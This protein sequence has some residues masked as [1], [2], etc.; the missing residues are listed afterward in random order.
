MMTHRRR[1]WSISNNGEMTVST[2]FD[3]YRLSKWSW[4]HENSADKWKCHHELDVRSRKFVVD[5]D[6]NH[7]MTRA[8][9]RLSA[10]I[11]FQTPRYI[12]SWL[13]NLNA[14]IDYQHDVDSW[15]N[16][17]RTNFQWGRYAF[18]HEHDLD[19]QPYTA[20][21]TTV[22][23]TTPF[24]GLEQLGIGFNNRRTLNGWRANNELLMGSTGNVTLDGSL[25]FHGYNF[26][27]MIRITTPVRHLERIVVIVRNAQHRDGMWA[28]HADL[29]YA[30][31]KAMSFDSKLSLG[32]ERMIELE[33]T[34]PFSRLRQLKYKAGCSGTWRNLRAYTELQHNMLGSEKIELTAS[35]RLEPKILAMAALRSPFENARRITLSFS[36]EGPWDNFKIVTELLYNTKKIATNLEFALREF[37][38]QHKA[39][40]MNG[41]IE[42]PF[43]HLRSLTYAINHSGDWRNFRNNLTVTYNGQEITGSSEFN[44]DF[45]NI[46]FEIRTPWRILSSY[47]FQHA[48]KLLGHSFVGWRNSWSAVID[49]QR[50]YGGCEC[51][52]NGNQLDIHLTANM[53]QEHSIRI[54]QVVNSANHFSNNIVIKLDSHQITEAMEFRRTRDKIDLQ[55]NTVSTFPGYERLDAVFKHELSDSGFTTTASLSTPF[56]AVRRLVFSLNHQGTPSDFSSRMTTVVNDKTITS[57]LTFKNNLRTMEGE[58]NIQTPFNGYDRF[59]ANFAFNGEPQ[60]FTASSTV[61]LPFDGYE[62]FYAELS[63]NGEWRRFETS[64][65]LIVP[66]GTSSA[67]LIH[68]G[69][70]SN[71]TTHLEIRTPLTGYSVFQVGIEHEHLDNLKTSISVRTPIQGYENFGLTLLKTGDVRNL[72]L[73]AEMTTTIRHLER[74]AVTWSHNVPVNRRSVELRGML[75]TSFSHYQR[76]SLTASQS[77]VQRSVTTNVLIETSIPGYSRFVT[78]TE[79][80]SSRRNWKWSG[81]C[82]T[83][84]DGYERW[85]A[86]IEHAQNA[87]SDGFRTVVQTTTPI[88]NYNNFAATLSHSGEA[89]QFRTR[90]QVNLPFRKVPQIDVTLMHRGAS[91]T[92]FATSLSV[93]F[94]GKKTELETAFKMGLVRQTEINYEGRFRLVAPCP[95]VREFNITASHNNKPETKAGAVKIVFNGEEKVCTVI[96]YF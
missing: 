10:K 57:T 35:F 82:E 14:S 72:Q 94:A 39:L 50:Q 67:K 60:H 79:Y 1:G 62:R 88:N 45:S 25:N 17:G 31:D 89:S 52:W 80:F 71:F 5:I 42:T 24:P 49:G 13:Q 11:A 78:V 4:N 86:G 19:I 41:N 70:V 48:N 27:S 18:G 83:S 81:S 47:N 51:S 9:R 55:L 64:G 2:P 92:D 93:D 16:S 90:L 87:R 53:P 63:H 33:A 30:S 96:P 84:I 36:Q 23:M 76:M 68:S 7:G 65:K 38:L 54:S 22:K 85:T 3:G 26:D 46:K 37:Q 8:E 91:P 43:A 77:A 12:A 15:R 34:T 73:K 75:E 61:R 20:F 56:E 40:R 6:A 29:Q 69:D 32:N 66:S 28:S 21:V 58:L 44:I 59:H 74:T 95:Y